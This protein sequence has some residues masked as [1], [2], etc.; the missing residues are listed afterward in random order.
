MLNIVNISSRS[1]S[2][3][4]I[5]RTEAK[6]WLNVFHTT[7]DDL[8]DDL[9]EDAVY[10]WEERTGEILR[11]A[12]GTVYLSEWPACIELN[13]RPIRTVTTINYV[14][15]DQVSQTVSAADYNLDAFGIV[16]RITFRPEYTFPDLD[17]DTINPIVITCVMGYTASTLPGHVRQAIRY[18]VADMYQHRDNPVRDRKSAYDRLVTVSQSYIP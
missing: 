18:M 14:D 12:T 2:S 1:A 4:P 13:R 15:T 6:N 3:L 8:I 17:D 5:S 11:Q 9:I 16:P 10:E 7:H